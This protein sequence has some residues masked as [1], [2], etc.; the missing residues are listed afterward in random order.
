MSQVREYLR[1]KWHGNGR[2]VGTFEEGMKFC[3]VLKCKIEVPLF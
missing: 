1:T 2:S 3:L